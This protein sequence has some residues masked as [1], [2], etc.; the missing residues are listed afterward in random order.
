MKCSAKML[1][2]V[3]RKKYKKKK[4]GR[5]KQNKMKWLIKSAQISQIMIVRAITNPNN[6]VDVKIR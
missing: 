1:K 2:I 3:K 4:N 5:I 6:L